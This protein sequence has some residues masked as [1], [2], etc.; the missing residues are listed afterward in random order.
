[1]ILPETSECPSGNVIYVNGHLVCADDGT[2]VDDHPVVFDIDSN[3]EDVV[4]NRGLVTR[5]VY[6]ARDKALQILEL[7]KQGLPIREI[8]ARTGIRSVSAIYS[9]VR[10][11]TALR[12]RKSSHR[13]LSREEVAEICREYSDGASIYSIAKKWGLSTSRIYYVVKRHCS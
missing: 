12:K 3:V 5:V 11:N 1:M 7:Y 13:R 2:V 10:A 6:S 9:I 8:M 4:R